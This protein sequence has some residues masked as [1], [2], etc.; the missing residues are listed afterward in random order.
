[1]S[2]CGGR[3]HNYCNAVDHNKG[4]YF[5]TTEGF[6][7]SKKTLN[8]EL[9]EEEEGVVEDVS[10]DPLMHST[11]EPFNSLLQLRQFVS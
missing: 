6:K 9:E 1:M 8:L 2:K 11:C 4:N 10:T 3:H 5:D 7:E